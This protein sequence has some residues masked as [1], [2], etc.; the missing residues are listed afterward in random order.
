VTYPGANAKM[1]ASALMF[2]LTLV[3]L[4]DRELGRLWRRILGAMLVGD[5]EAVAASPFIS[6]YRTGLPDGARAS[7]TKSLRR[8]VLARDGYTCQRCS[9]RE[10]LEVDHINP[11]AFGGSDDMSNLQTLCRPCNRAK[12]PRAYAASRGR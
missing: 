11:V 8:A 1:D 7:V 9:A 4:S 6:G 2:D 5:R 3:P 10:L 12:G